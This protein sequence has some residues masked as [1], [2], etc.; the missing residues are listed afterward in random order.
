MDWRRSHRTSQLAHADKRIE[1]H[2]VLSFF[3]RGSF[4]NDWDK[5]LESTGSKLANNMKLS[6]RLQYITG[7]NE[8]PV[9]WRV[10]LRREADI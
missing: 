2:K 10:G 7:R 4:I 9:G 1:V 3:L 5:S 8:I 6:V